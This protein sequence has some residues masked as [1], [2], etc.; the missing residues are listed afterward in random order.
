M[1]KYK[2]TLNY[3]NIIVETNYYSCMAVIP[4]H[5]YDDSFPCQQQIWSASVLRWVMLQ[6][7]IKK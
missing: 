6:I 5:V 2:Y 3:C 7:L 4:C 1:E